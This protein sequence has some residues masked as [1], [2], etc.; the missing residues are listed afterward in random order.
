MNRDWLLISTSLLI[1]TPTLVLALEPDSRFD[2]SRGQPAVTADTVGVCTDT[3]TARFDWSRGQPMVVYDTTASC[4]A[5]VSDA[6]AQPHT[7]IGGNAYFGGNVYI[8]N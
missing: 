7:F 8:G 5:V 4:D 2:W 6:T 3:T 1:F